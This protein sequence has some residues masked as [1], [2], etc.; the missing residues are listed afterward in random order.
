MR[1][2]PIIPGQASLARWDHGALIANGQTL[3]MPGLMSV[4]EGTLSLRQQWGDFLLLAYGAA[5]HYT[6]DLG[7]TTQWG[8]GGAL[9]YQMTD[10]IRWTVFGAYHTATGILQPAMAGY[11]Q[12][13]VYGGYIDYRFNTRG[14]GVKVGAQSYYDPMRRQ[15]EAQPILMPYYRS[16]SID[17]GGILYQAIKMGTSH[18]GKHSADPTIMP[19]KVK[20]IIPPHP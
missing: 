16:V 14:A 15:W 7:L 8:F 20:P 3:L 4:E 17:L 1:P 9:S 10:H 18:P 6:S 13:P 5:T 11:I 12:T 2:T 19:T